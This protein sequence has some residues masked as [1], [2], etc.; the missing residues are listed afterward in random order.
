M[1]TLFAFSNTFAWS[2]CASC[3]Q[4]WSERAPLYVFV[5]LNLLHPGSPSYAL[6]VPNELKAGIQETDL[7][8]K[9]FSLM[10]SFM[11]SVASDV[12]CPCPTFRCLEPNSAVSD[13]PGA[14]Q[15]RVSWN[16]FG[17]LVTS[18]RNAP[19]STAR[20]P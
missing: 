16:K 3:L 17:F 2:N 11:L 20:S 15:W 9:P 5:H 1:F 10:M 4:G 14:G 12:R 19:S 18:S 7:L 13:F 6:L 8:G